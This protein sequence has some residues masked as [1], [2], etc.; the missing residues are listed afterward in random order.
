MRQATAEPTTKSRSGLLRRKERQ[1]VQKRPEDTMFFTRLRTHAKWVFVLLAAAFAIG[2]LAFGI[3]TGGGGVGDFIRE[4]LGSD[5]G[6]TSLSEL[7][8]KVKDNPTDGEAVVQL[9]SLLL[10]QQRF[11]EAT[12]V[13]EAYT[14]LR[15]KDETAL[16]QLAQAYDFRARLALQNANALRAQAAVG[17]FGGVAFSFPSDSGFFGAVGQSPIE[18]ALTA[19]FNTEAFEQGR[20]SD[21]FYTKEVA[22]LQ[23]LTKLR[24]DDATL[25]AQLGSTAVS[26][27]DN[28]AAIAAYEKYLE[29][30][31]DGALA[32]QT[33]EQLNQ[34]K[35]LED[36]SVEGVEQTG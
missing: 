4:L 33:K 36:G 34:L 28:D 19:K 5:S 25:Y 13:L 23:E 18:D 20:Q 14:K 2:F 12:G 21:S 22:A 7:Q 8:D 17:S 27:G 10:S 16:T 35:A 24:P 30:E 1:P 9:S 15:P 3:G 31:P 6:T 32:Q 11:G 29:L 26:A